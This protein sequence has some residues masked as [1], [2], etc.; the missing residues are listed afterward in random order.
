MFNPYVP[1]PIDL[2]REVPL[3]PDADL[4]EL[5]TAKILGAPPDPADWPAWRDQLHRW[6]TDARRRVPHD[7]ARY[8]TERGGVFVVDVL[9]LWD[10]LIYDH[11]LQQFALDRYLEHA[12]REFG[13][14]DGVLL[15][16]GYPDIGIDDRDQYSYY[17]DVPELPALVACLQAA[18]IH[19][20]VVV[21]PWESAEPRQIRE[22]AEWTGADGVFF[23]AVKEGSVEARKELDELR[24]GIT[25]E[26][27]SPLPPERLGDQTMAWAQWYA[28][29]DVPGVLRAKWFERRHMLHHVRRWH[30]DH[31]AELH[32]AWLNGV[33]VIVWETVFGVWVGWSPRDKHLLRTMRRV[34]RDFAAW[35]C[36]EDWTPLADHPGPDCPVVASRWEFGGSVLWTLVNR[37]DEPY[38]GVLLDLDAADGTVFTDVGAGLSLGVTAD[39]GRVR[40]SGALAPGGITAIHDRAVHPAPAVPAQTDSSFPARAAVRT[41]P[42]R[43]SQLRT[44]A[45]RASGTVDGAIVPSARHDLVVTYRFRETGLYG[46]APFVDEWKPLPPRLHHTATLHRSVHLEGFRVARREVT[47]AEYA[48]FVTATGYRPLRAERFLAH[49]VDGRPAPGTE[50]QPVTY[51][52]LSDARAYA[53]WA[54]CRLPSEDEWQVAAEA[55]HLERLAPLVW[56]LTES[57]HTDGRTR[58]CILKGGSDFV[59]DGSDWY[60]DGGPQAASHSAKYLVTGSGLFRSPWLGFRCAVSVDLP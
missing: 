18:G 46:E 48:R 2:Y 1:R 47:N 55:G 37:S 40:V 57:E 38:D 51:V 50:E 26:A 35:L 6:L 53:S 15:W 12:E 54:G 31:L 32:S 27:E 11:E 39:S 16:H 24:P 17:R 22:L 36:S 10:E 4:R 30:R 8:D 33:G 20:Q 60:F 52:D 25:M 34:H 29:S 56:N 43:A 9:W 41:S 59:R 19:V 44:S 7:S 13:G 45:G 14:V 3:A 5:D 58:F 28:D 23:D 42:P 49:W 21:Y